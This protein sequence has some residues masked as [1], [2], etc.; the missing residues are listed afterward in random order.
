M[1]FSESF[2]ELKKLINETKELK[3]E[4]GMLKIE[5]R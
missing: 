4:I 5:I 2:D 3:D 1:A